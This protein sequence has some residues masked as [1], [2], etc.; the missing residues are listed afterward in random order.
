MRLPAF[1]LENW[2]DRYRPHCRYNIASSDIEGLALDELLSLCDRETRTLWNSLTLGYSHSLGHPL[3]R[4]EIAGLYRGVEPEDVHA[5]AGTTEAVFAAV[6]AALSPGDHAVVI[7]PT[8]QL[9]TGLPA[10]VGA[11]VDLVELTGRDGWALDVD[12]VRSV[13]RPGTRLLVLNAP[14][15]PTGALPSPDQVRALAGLA[16]SLGARLLVDEVYRGLEAPEAAPPSGVELGPHVVTVSGVSK[17]YGLA[18]LRIGWVASTD[19]DYRESLREFR[20]WTTLNNSLPSEILA[21]VALRARA[22]LLG[23]ARGIVTANRALLEDFLAQHSD[24]FDWVPTRAGTTAYP[25]LLHDDA[26]CAAETLAT[27]H[28]VFVVPSSVIPGAGEHLRIGLGRTGLSE[29][30]DA[31]GDALAS[32]TPGE[33]SAKGTP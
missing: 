1:L 14:N 26:R 5:F 22:T 33:L 12:R 4:A 31:L 16:E 17:V 21:I 24:W 23:R 25:R 19:V 8:Y 32:A 2:I 6:S 10:A 20:Y 30:L 7:G 11:D 3:L 27:R 9:L 28:G 18:G 13:C 29:G 15:N